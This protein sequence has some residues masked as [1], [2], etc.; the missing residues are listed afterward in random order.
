MGCGLP[1]LT[2][3][4]YIFFFSPSSYVYRYAIVT[5]GWG[6]AMRFQFCIFLLSIG[7]SRDAL[8][9]HLR[10]RCLSKGDS[11]KQS[12]QPPRPAFQRLLIPGYKCSTFLLFHACNSS[13]LRQQELVL[14]EAPVVFW[15]GIQYLLHF[16]TWNLYK[17]S[18]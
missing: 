9:M 16:I 14:A 7:S 2:Y 18:M 5:P 3:Q 13:F 12:P 17:P 1:S 8:A 11:K 10:V 15:A 4:K 6:L